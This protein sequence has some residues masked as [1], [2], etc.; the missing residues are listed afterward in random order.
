MMS[1]KALYYYNLF[2]NNFM[3]G[4]RYCI[5]LIDG[6]TLEGVP[7]SG[8]FLAPNRPNRTFLLELRDSVQEI[9]FRDVV[10]AK[11]IE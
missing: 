1:D 6:K 9:R 8:S 4:D 2:L 7:R 5:K 3:R 10:C 11:K